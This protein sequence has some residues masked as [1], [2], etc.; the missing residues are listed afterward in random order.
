M[1]NYK[2]LSKLI[3]ENGVILNHELKIN[4]IYSKLLLLN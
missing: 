2:E 1:K 4:N 3:D